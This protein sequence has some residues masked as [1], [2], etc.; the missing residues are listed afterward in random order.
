MKTNTHFLSYLAQFF[1]E[2]EM[3]PDK[4]VEKI[5]THFMFNKVFRKSRLLWDNAEKYCGT[6]QAKDDNMVHAWKFK[7]FE[8]RCS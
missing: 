4:F 6:G 5:E 3:L 1:L 2:L 8:Y 7:S